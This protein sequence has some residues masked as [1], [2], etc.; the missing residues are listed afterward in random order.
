MEYNRMLCW[1]RPHEKKELKS[2]IGNQF[3]VVF[4]KSFE[5]FKRQITPDSYL[6]FSAVHAKQSKLKNLIQSFP[7][8][9]FRIYGEGRNEEG[10][11]Q[12]FFLQDEPNV[13]KG[14]Y[15]T[16]EFVD[17]YQ[18]KIKDLWQWRRYGIK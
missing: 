15:M 17:N 4:A 9:I 6:I 2:V 5:D 16:E 13:Q 1:V 10:I 14:K 18:G 12:A 8:N 7:N 3:P 11:D